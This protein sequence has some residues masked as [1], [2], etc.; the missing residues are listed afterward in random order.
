MEQL[1][2]VEQNPEYHPEGDV[3]THTLMVMDEA[4]KLRKEA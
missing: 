4:A 1:I 3:W 2:G